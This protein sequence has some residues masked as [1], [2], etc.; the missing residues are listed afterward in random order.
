MTWTRKLRSKDCTWTKLLLEKEML[1]TL[2]TYTLATEMK[3]HAEELNIEGDPC[4]DDFIEIFAN[5]VNAD[6]ELYCW[7]KATAPGGTIGET[8]GDGSTCTPTH[9][10]PKWR[11]S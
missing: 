3:L 11:K 2:E 10:S 8:W 4:G 6:S 7:D 5:H 1:L 9:R